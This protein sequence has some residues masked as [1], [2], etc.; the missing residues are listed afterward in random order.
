MIVKTSWVELCGKKNNITKIVPTVG[1]VVISVINTD[2]VD[3]E[4]EI[5]KSPDAATLKPIA[6]A[7]NRLKIVNKLK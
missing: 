5:K 7:F 3:D 2:G 1:T 4:K 6:R